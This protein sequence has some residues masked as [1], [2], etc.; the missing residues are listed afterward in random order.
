[1]NGGADV[2]AHDPL[3]SIVTPVLDRV[4]SVRAALASVAAQTYRPIEHLVIDGGST[5][6][7]V[8]AI[9]EF[10]KTA[11]WVRWISEP[12]SGMYEAI[13]KGIRMAKGHIC[14]YLNSDDLYFPWSVESAVRRLQTGCDF[15]FG[16]VA[17]FVESDDQQSF[18]LQFYRDFDPRYY[19]HHGVLAQPTVFWTR[20]AGETV[21]AFNEDRRLLGDVDYW[22]RAAVAGLRFCRLQ[23]VLALVRLH[24]DALSVRFENEMRAELISIRSIGRERYRPRIPLLVRIDESL[25]WRTRQFQFRRDAR[26]EH[27]RRWPQ[28][29]RLL[30]QLDIDVGGSAMLSLLLPGR[31]LRN[32]PAAQRMVHPPEAFY[33][34]YLASLGHPTRKEGQQPA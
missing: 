30:R 15:V 1:M 3:V 31:W 18:R 25:H 17:I 26:R 14:S 24:P 28:F 11:P 13:Q 16:D 4:D 32:R 33:N 8:E 9:E 10:S 19:I 2:T 22:T 20:H 23:E 6:G 29:I 34:R 21:G 27:P 7:T 12:D 5:D